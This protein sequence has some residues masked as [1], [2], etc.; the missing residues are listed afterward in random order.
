[1]NL[2]SKNKRRSL[3]ASSIFVLLVFLFLFTEVIRTP[4]ATLVKTPN[5]SATLNPTSNILPSSRPTSSPELSA[6]VN[7]NSK[8]SPTYSL[9]NK[10]VLT[11]ALPTHESTPAYKPSGVIVPKGKTVASKTKSGSQTITVKTNKVTVS[12]TPTAAGKPTPSQPPIQVAPVA[13][14]PASDWSGFI[15]PKVSYVKMLS[16]VKSA[17]QEVNP[18]S[19]V[20]SYSFYLSV[21]LKLTD[22]HFNYNAKNYNTSDTVYITDPT[23]DGFSTN[24]M[25]F[26]AGLWKSTELNFFAFN[27]KD[28][29]GGPTNGGVS[30]AGYRTVQYSYLFH[31]TQ[32]ECDSLPKP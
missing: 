10:H 2:E 11:S 4:S 8:P 6:T 13:P 1:M 22:G 23:M 32:A 30:D 14:L 19:G 24:S 12:V 27:W 15:A 16:C 21:Q 18:L 3:Y 28:N 9:A 17:T 7:N 29:G 20:L 31:S 26:S 5:S 25:D